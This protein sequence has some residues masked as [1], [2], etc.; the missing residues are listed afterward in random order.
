MWV[1]AIRVVGSLSAL[2]NASLL[3]EPVLFELQGLR[4]LGDGAHDILWHALRNVRADL[5]LHLDTGADEADEVRHDLGRDLIGV[6]R[7]ALRVDRL[8]P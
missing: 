6:A 1:A 5:E 7:D 2:I 3:L 4:V 8:D